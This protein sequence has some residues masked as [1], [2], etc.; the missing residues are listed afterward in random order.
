MDRQYQT[1]DKTTVVS[2]REK[3]VFLSRMDE[4]GAKL[5]MEDFGLSDAV[6][7]TAESFE[8]IALSKEKTLTVNVEPAILYHGNEGT[9]RQLVS[10][11][12]DNAMKYS[13]EKG[14]I[15]LTLKENGKSKVLTVENTV[16]NIA[17]G[18]LDILF[19]RF[20]RT[21]ESRNSKTGGH[22]VGLSV[23]RAIAVAHKGKI[24]AE[25]RD[26]KRILFTVIL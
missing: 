19:E 24:S 14:Q 11:L 13:D 10:L 3:L 15:T 6:L 7:E 23:A 18:N 17:V 2:D 9:I 21:D 25:S 8:A 5:T 1:A 4:D 12:L 20:Y 22:G 16:E 26:G